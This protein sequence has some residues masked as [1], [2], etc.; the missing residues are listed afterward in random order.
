MSG[1]RSRAL[2]ALVALAMVPTLALPLRAGAEPLATVNAAARPA[3][4]N[5]ISIPIVNAEARTS[6]AT[7]ARP[8]SPGTFTFGVYPGGGTGE[9]PNAPRPSAAAVDARMRDLAGGKPFVAHLYTAWSWHADW[10][11]AEVKRFTDAGMG[12]VLTV[13]YSPPAGHEGDIA[14]YEQFVRKIVRAYGNNP[15]VVSFCIGNE[16]NAYGNP[17]ASDGPFAG[18]HAAVARGVVAARDE[19]NQMGSRAEVGFNFTTKNPTEDAAFVRELAE[20]GGPAFAP[21]VG[22]VGVQVYP[23]I[24]TPG[25]EPYA[26]MSS[27]LESA[28]TSVNAVPGLRAVPLEVLETGAP[29]LDQDEQRVRMAKFVQ[30]TVDASAR[31][32]IVHFNW[33]DLWDADSSSGNQFNHYGLLRSDLSE[34]PAYSLFRETVA[35]LTR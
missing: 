26:D 21:S 28:R 29:I 20:L 2:T 25:R 32:N 14:G 8:L 12:V 19:L 22:I 18:S 33:F 5:R 35:T 6:T 13:K 23:G 15:G 7:A 34:K 1:L 17:D 24:W 16:A 4:T 11:D 10:V 9:T 30:A 3:M 27:A 31:L